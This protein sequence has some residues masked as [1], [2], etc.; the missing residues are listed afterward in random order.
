MFWRD[1][2]T[3]RDTNFLTFYG[4][5]EQGNRLHEDPELFA[6]VQQANAIIDPAERKVAFNK[7]A[8]RLR[9]ES[10]QMGLGYFNLPYAVGPRVAAWQPWPMAYHPTN[11][12]GI[13]LK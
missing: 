9:E 2:N 11:L 4:T 1:N 13:T 5:P 7:V 6:L 8:K 12:Q 10:Y 3:A